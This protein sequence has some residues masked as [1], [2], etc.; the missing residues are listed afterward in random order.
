[1]LKHSNGFSLSEKTFQKWLTGQ[2]YPDWDHLFHLVSLTK[3]TIEYLVYGND[4]IEITR[5]LFETDANNNYCVTQEELHAAFVS[6]L[7][8]AIAFN[9]MKLIDNT[10][11]EQIFNAFTI[12][13]K[14]GT[15]VILKEKAEG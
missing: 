9:L 13:L 10:T 3:R 8:Q 7:E 12:K 14:L 5:A 6:T 15:R 1:M 2:S 4:S 11:P